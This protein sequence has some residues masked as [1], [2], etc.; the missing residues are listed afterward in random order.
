M[1]CVHRKD[2]SRPFGPPDVIRIVLISYNVVFLEV[3]NQPPCHAF[4]VET[5]SSCV[6]KKQY[7]R[8]V[9]NSICK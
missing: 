8:A 2:G 7:V 5:S 1:E 6:Q 4:D 3:A 9:G